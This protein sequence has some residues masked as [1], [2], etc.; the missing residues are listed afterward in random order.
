MFTALE[1]E[2]RKSG[3]LPYVGAK[4]DEIQIIISHQITT[5]LGKDM[6]DMTRII[7]RDILEGMKIEYRE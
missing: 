4:K 5:K 6:R 2:T 7:S 3:N 1:N